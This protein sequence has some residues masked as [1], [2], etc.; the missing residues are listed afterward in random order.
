M[1]RSRRTYHSPV[2]YIIVIK[3]NTLIDYYI[4]L[5]YGVAFWGFYSLLMVV[6]SVGDSA[7]SQKFTIPFRVLVLAG[8]LLWMSYAKNK[9]LA[10]QWNAFMYAV[11][12][13]WLLYFMRILSDGVVFP[14]VLGKSWTLYLSQTF[15]I[16]VI[17]MFAFAF[18][19]TKKQ[20]IASMFSV[21]FFAVL[22]VTLGLIFN[23]DILAGG[24]RAATHGGSGVDHSTLISPHVFSYAG[25]SIVVICSNYLFYL[26]K[27][28]FKQRSF[29]YL[30]LLIGLIGMFTGES[31]GPVISLFL[32][33]NCLFIVFGKNGSPLARAFYLF[34][35]NLFL[36]LVVVLLMH[37]FSESDVF[38]RFSRLFEGLS[39]FD[40][41]AG[42]GR[43]GMWK[44]GASQFLSNPIFG[45]GL[46]ERGARYI[47]HLAYLEAFMATGLFG[48]LLYLGV[49]IYGVYMSF[50]VLI[51]CPSYSWLSFL[52]LSQFFMGWMSS[53]AANLYF[54]FPLMGVWAVYRQMHVKRPHLKR[55]QLPIRRRN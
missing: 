3:K 35:G 33:M 40:D 28:N 36:V 44:A 52:Y 31:R 43:L 42:S 55:A 13:F 37:V 27:G 19:I 46:E 25:L 26:R 5:L 50:K 1:L 48:G 10:P 6:Y 9:R 8:T 29:V 49:S 23:R 17:P 20:S 18:V 21:L 39:Q 45:S 15:G 24:Y 53:S 41:S 38:S 2:N 54:W 47:V 7:L 30:C 34:I 51:A 14:V 4:P 11:I 32:I 22:T 16:T 12:A